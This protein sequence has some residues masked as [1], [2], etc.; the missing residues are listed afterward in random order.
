MNIFEILYKKSGNVDSS[1]VAF[2]LDRV[3]IIKNS[4]DIHQIH[5][6]GINLFQGVDTDGDFISVRIGKGESELTEVETMKIIDQGI[7]RFYLLKNMKLG[8][9][10]KKQVLIYMNF[11]GT[12][13]LYNFDNKVAQSFEA[14]VKLGEISD[15]EQNITL[16]RYCS[17]GIEVFF[18]GKKGLLK[19]VFV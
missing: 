1:P 12:V 13:G 17:Q 5:G 18:V 8:K 2:K 4:A 14:P 9:S 16:N 15:S 10:T 19:L 3:R 6:T 11:G 7:D